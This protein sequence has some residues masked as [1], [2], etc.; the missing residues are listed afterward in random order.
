MNKI[1]VLLIC[2]CF[3]ASCSLGGLILQPVSSPTPRAT[4]TKTYTPIPSVTP[5]TPTLTFTLTPTLS[6]LKSATPTLEFSPTTESSITP[7]ALITPNTPTATIQMEG[8]VSVIVS[9]TEFY[10]GTSC[11]PSSVKF[12]AQVANAGLVDQVSLAARFTSKTSGNSGSWS[13]FNMQPVG[14][15]TYSYELTAA[16]IKGDTLYRNPWVDYQ[17]IAITSTLKEVGRTEV[18]KERLSLLECAPPTP[19]P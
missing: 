15:G 9:S 10:R 7:L 12:S 2:A 13:Y 17:F 18:F 3:T 6:G 1:I 5:V 8:F 16:T 19:T 14:G 11:F 4:S